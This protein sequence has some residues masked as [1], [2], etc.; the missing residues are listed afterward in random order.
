MSG[1]LAD[2][3]IAFDILDQL[4][5]MSPTELENLVPEHAKNAYITDTDTLE[6]MRLAIR[7]TL[8]AEAIRE[9]SFALFQ[10]AETARRLKLLQ[11][12]PD[13]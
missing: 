2:L 11:S 5:L 12:N 3:Y 10:Q 6:K 13:A 7:E 9:G 1:R 4:T 8:Y